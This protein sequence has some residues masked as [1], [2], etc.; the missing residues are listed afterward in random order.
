MPL[1]SRAVERF[2]DALDRYD[3][4][5]VDQRSC[6]GRDRNRPDER[7]I[8]VV[9][10]ARDMDDDPRSASIVAPLMVNDLDDAGREAVVFVERARGSV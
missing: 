3:R 5:K 1:R 2:F 4:A 9:E 6:G 8:G 10:D 7:A